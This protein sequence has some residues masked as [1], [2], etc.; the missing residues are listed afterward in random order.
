MIAVGFPAENVPL[1]PKLRK[2]LV[3]VARFSGE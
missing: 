3:E 1:R 2:P